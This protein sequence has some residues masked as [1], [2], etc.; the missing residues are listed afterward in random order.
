MYDGRLVSIK[1]LYCQ[2]KNMIW[3]VFAGT[4][5]FF[6]TG[7]VWIRRTYGPLMLAMADESF[8]N[9]LRNKRTLFAGSVI[10]PTLAVFILT[11]V[12][13]KIWKKPD[14]IFITRVMGVVAVA[15]VCVVVA[16]LEVPAYVARQHRLRQEQWYDT[17]D[18]VMHALG[19]IDDIHYTNSKEALEN[20]YAS[21]NRLFECD[22]SMTADGKLVACHDWEFWN[23]NVTMETKSGGRYK[24]DYIPT[25]DVFMEHRFSGKYTPLSVADVVLFLKEHPDAYVITDTKCVE[26][27]EIRMYFQELVDVAR[28]NACEETLDRFVVQIYRGYML[29]IAREIYPFPNYI[30]TLY[31]EA[32]K[33]EEDKMQ[34]YAEFCMLQDIDVITMEAKYYRDELQNIC[35]RYG[36]RLF[37]H[38]VND[39]GELETFHEKGVGVYTD[40]AD[41]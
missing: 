38:T 20:S 32:Y 26:P 15:S 39:Q 17:D 34:E 10:L 36:I 9:G 23:E 11:L 37:V 2:S 35:S 4:A 28:E 30:F 33:G 27:E 1:T 31:Y 21:G 25:L 29:G 6:F 3:T 19:G 24:S 18:R 16:V 5:A 8:R 7:T 12:I 40:I 41:R 22:M 13:H 14:R